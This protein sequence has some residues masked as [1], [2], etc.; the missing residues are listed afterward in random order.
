M[1][2]CSFFL[3]LTFEFEFEWGLSAQFESSHLQGESIQS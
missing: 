2:F 1:S 3:S